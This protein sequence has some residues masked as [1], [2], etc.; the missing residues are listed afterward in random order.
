L[1]WRWGHRA[2]EARLL[3][4]AR[5][6]HTARI[7]DAYEA[8][9]FDGL[10]R[11]EWSRGQLGETQNA[12]HRH[13]SIWDELA[14]EAT[15][16]AGEAYAARR[17]REIEAAREES[18][19]S[20]LD[21]WLSY[22]GYDLEKVEVVEGA[23][24]GLSRDLIGTGATIADQM[25]DTAVRARQRKIRQEG[26]MGGISHGGEGVEVEPSSSW[27]TLIYGTVVI[28]GGLPLEQPSHVHIW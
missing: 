16:G 24:Q 14:L 25:R 19:S 13:V 10:A 23:R 11:G 5:I 21:P 4:E 9:I 20:W 7:G 27:S 17:E 6:Q 8:G 12:Q 28:A 22:V 26:S 1:I 15:K 18:A 3:Q 2:A